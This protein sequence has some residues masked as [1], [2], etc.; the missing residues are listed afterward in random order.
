MKWLIEIKKCKN[1]EEID[2]DKNLKECKL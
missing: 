2:E 1:M